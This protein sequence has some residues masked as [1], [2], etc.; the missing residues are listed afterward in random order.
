MDATKNETFIYMDMYDYD[1]DDPNSSR[2][3][4]ESPQISK[5]FM[6]VRIVL[7]MLFFLGLLGMFRNCNTPL[8][9]KFSIVF[10]KA[11]QKHAENCAVS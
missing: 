5:G 10:Q 9:L 6:A 1:Y 8:L 7:C 2:F 11:T 4:E 3:G